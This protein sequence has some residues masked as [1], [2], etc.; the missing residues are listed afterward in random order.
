[1]KVTPK[2]NNAWKLRNGSVF[3]SEIDKNLNKFNTT[4][5]KKMKK[6]FYLLSKY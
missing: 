2:F 1:M 3:L 5:L 6:K 4:C